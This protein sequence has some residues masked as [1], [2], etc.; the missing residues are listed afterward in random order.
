MIQWL[1]LLAI[2]IFVVFNFLRHRN[3]NSEEIILPPGHRLAN[4]KNKDDEFA[5][6][7]IKTKKEIGQ[8]KANGDEQTILSREKY[9]QES[10]LELEPVTSDHIIQI[11]FPTKRISGHEMQIDLELT[12]TLVALTKDPYWIYV[13][14]VL[15]PDSPIGKWELKIHNLSQQTEKY[16]RINPQSGNWYLPINQPDQKFIFTLGIRDIDGKFN[17]IIVS[18][19]IHTPPNRPSDKVDA[20]WGTIKEFYGQRKFMK[21]EGSPEFISKRKG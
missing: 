10:G 16:E 5:E 19:E 17:P 13:Y 9:D 21:A 2:G 11:G 15:P 7:F 18:N 1:L 8:M 3:T 12:P 14:W 4:N 20:K 6:D